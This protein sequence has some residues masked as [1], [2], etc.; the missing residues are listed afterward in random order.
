MAMKIGILGGTFNPIHNGHLLI[1]QNALDQ[2]HL[3]KIWFMPAAIPPHKQDL[4]IMDAKH[5]M[6]M[7]LRGIEGNASF[8]L[9]PRE[10]IQG[11]VSYTYVTLNELKKECPENEYYF[12]I[13]ADSLKKF[14]TWKEPGKILEAATLLVAV[15]DHVKGQELDGLIEEITSAYGGRIERIYTPEFNVSSQEIRQR[16]QD[17]HSIRYLLPDNVCEYITQ[18]HLYEA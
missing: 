12:I 17:G 10:L 8:E 11:G 9:N 2:F 16:I 4:T 6:Q 13:G 3:D 5:R 14:K 1:A 18:E 15:R 7:I